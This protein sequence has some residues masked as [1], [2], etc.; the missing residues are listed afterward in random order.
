MIFACVAITRWL[1]PEEMPELAGGRQYFEKELA[2]LGPWSE[3]EKKSLLWFGLA[4]VLWSTDFMHR[5]NPA[6]IGLAAG[7]LLSL[8]KIGVLDRKAVRTIFLLSFFCRRHQ[9]GTPCR[10]TLCLFC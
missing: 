5:I 8:P 4:V 7:L 6:V 1:Y 10:Q 2:R 9:W 3:L